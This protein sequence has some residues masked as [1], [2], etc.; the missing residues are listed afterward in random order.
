MGYDVVS[1]DP[2][3]EVGLAFHE[4]GEGQYGEIAEELERFAC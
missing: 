4:T 2:G 1:G 3:C